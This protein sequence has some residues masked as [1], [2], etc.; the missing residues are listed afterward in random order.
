MLKHLTFKFL[1]STFCVL[2]SCVAT[3]PVPKDKES[4]PNPFIISDPVRAKYASRYLILLD[5]N[6]AREQKEAEVQLKKVNLP[7]HI[8]S[9]LN[10]VNNSD[11]RIAEI[12][13]RRLVQEGKAIQSLAKFETDSLAEWDSARKELVNIGGDALTEMVQVLS[14]K[15]IAYDDKHKEWIREQISLSGQPVLNAVQLVLQHNK[16]AEIAHQLTL[17]LAEM[18]QPAEKAINEL[19]ATPN[20]S[21]SLAAT[22]AMGESGVEYWTDK[23]GN[24]LL[25]D[26][27]WQVRAEAASALG[28]LVDPR[29]SVFLIKGLS[30][31]DL[32]VKEKCVTSLGSLKEQD[33]LPFLIKMI[34]TKDNPIIV[35]TVIN[36][37]SQITGRRFNN[38]E[39]WKR[40]WGENKNGMGFR[41]ND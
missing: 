12:A 31:T 2:A 5:N 9:L 16:N 20:I 22:S 32:L 17:A 40:W 11:K 3:D 6:S 30:D 38:P 29:A 4:L 8:R 21:L 33:A 41:E 34:D 39:A 25:T 1:L 26:S 28:V 18:G 14:Y 27:R 37:L 19:I 10:N 36:V 15:I 23:L 24:M 35:S 13:R 7:A